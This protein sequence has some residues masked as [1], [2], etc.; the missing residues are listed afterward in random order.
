MNPRK[1]G[2]TSQGK[3]M[4]LGCWVNFLGEWESG[5]NQEVRHPGNIQVKQC[6]TQGSGTQGS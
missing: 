6:Q 2:S 4:K 5:W 1:L 3:W